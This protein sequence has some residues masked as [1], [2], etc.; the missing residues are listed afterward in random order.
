[1]KI[2]K[3]WAFC[4]ARILGTPFHNCELPMALDVIRDINAAIG[5]YNKRVPG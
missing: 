1:M 4:I 2:V 3:H 5:L